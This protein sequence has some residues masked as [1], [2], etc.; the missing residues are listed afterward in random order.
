M[1]YTSLELKLVTKAA[2]ITCTGHERTAWACLGQAA[3][4][5]SSRCPGAKGQVLS[6]QAW[7][8]TCSVLLKFLYL[9]T[10]IYKGKQEAK[11]SGGSK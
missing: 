2:Y 10:V 4:L 5:I 9:G 1:G 3:V 6:V 8:H 7:G 11:C